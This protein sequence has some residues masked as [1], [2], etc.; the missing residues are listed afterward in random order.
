[1]SKPPRDRVTSRSN[2]YFITATA[3]GNRALFQSERVAN[4]LIET[5][6]LYRDQRKF[7]L[8]EFVVMPNHIHLLLTTGR[9]TTL[10]R[11]VQLIKGGFSYCARRELGVRRAI[12]QR[13]FSEDRV[14]SLEEYHNFRNYI[15]NN[16]VRAGLARTPEEYPYST[17]NAKFR[18]TPLKSAAAKAL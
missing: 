16:P 12:W 15:Y 4:L 6:L 11:G 17:A 3:N 2:T 7:F 8:H 18:R 10:E 5:L 14:R 9:E 1:M 13:G